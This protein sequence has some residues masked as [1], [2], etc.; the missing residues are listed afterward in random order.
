MFRKSSFDSA[1]SASVGA[2][3]LP[4]DGSQGEGRAR[5]GTLSARTS[6]RTA[7]SSGFFA[8]AARNSGSLSARS[9]K[10]GRA[11]V[12]GRLLLD[13]PL[14]ERGIGFRLEPHPIPVG[15]H[16]TCASDSQSA[17]GGRRPLRCRAFRPRTFVGSDRSLSFC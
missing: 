13:Q 3:S 14:D 6:S 10:S 8:Q 2:C 16:V 5:E 12:S 1:I 11:L 4:P 9:L 7:S 17:D 15:P